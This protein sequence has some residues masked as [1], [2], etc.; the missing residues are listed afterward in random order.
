M[1][2]LWGCLVLLLVG[3]GGGLAQADSTWRIQ[4]LDS[5]G[6]VGYYSSLALDSSGYPRI[7]YYDN[8]NLDLKYAAWNGTSWAIEPVDSAG[9]AGEFISLALDSNGYPRISYSYGQWEV[10]DLKYAAWDPTLNGGLGDWAIETVDSAGIVGS[11]T[12]LALDSSGSPHISYY[13][14]S[15]GN[16]KYAAWDPTLNGGL[17]DWA[18]EPVDTGIDVGLCSSLALDSFGFAHISYYANGA[19]KYAAWDGDSWAIEAVDSAAGVG[20]WTSLALDSS[21]YPHISYYDGPNGNLKYA[22]WDGS[23]WDLEPVDSTGSVGLYTSLALDSSGYPRIS[24]WDATNGDLKYAAWNGT[25]WDLQTLDS[26]GNVGQWTSLALDSFG[27]AHISYYD[28]TNGDLKYA[29][30]V[31]EPGTIALFGLGLLGLGT[32]LRRRRQAA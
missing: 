18:I 28:T 25:S 1:R 27:F 13:D 15:N 2:Y 32:K 19:L 22:A 11:F 14:G 3:L 26:A 29:N 6:D 24:Y 10:Y 4:T 16:L 23:A 20:S 12:S 8:S 21:G 5:P 30:N 9:Q 31:P 7:S 17:G